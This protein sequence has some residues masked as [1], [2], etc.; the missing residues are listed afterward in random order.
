MQAETRTNE[1]RVIGQIATYPDV[2]TVR[3]VSEILKVS[4]QT[5][6]EW[7]WAGVLPVIRLA[8]AKR[9]VRIRRDDLEEFIGGRI[10]TA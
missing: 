7:T 4:D 6:Y 5:V 1:E 9:A 8:S 10:R 2:L 3:E